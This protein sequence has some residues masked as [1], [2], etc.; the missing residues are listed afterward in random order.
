MRKLK[1]SYSE[2]VGAPIASL[3][4]LFDGKRINDDETPK[5]LEMEQEDVIEV[6]QEQTG[7]GADEGDDVELFSVE[8]KLVS[9][10][11]CL[12]SQS[13]ELKSILGPVNERNVKIKEGVL[14]LAEKFRKLNRI[15]ERQNS[16][17]SKKA[18][19]IFDNIN[20]EMIL[21][22]AENTGVKAS[23]L[24]NGISN[25]I[26]KIVSSLTELG[27]EFSFLNGKKSILYFNQNKKRDKNLPKVDDAKR[28][29]LDDD[30]I[31]ELKPTSEI[32]NLNT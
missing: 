16:I 31:I 3:R 29:K 20:N 28:Q 15:Y 6:Y 2:R 7:G 14:A 21:S 1:K 19:K 22:F 25:S 32:E 24:S 11:A 13:L 9:E 30:D 4:F 17:K 26:S 8:E 12:I 27:M 23:Q 18:D 5:S 10:T